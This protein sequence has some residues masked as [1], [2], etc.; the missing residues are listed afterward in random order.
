MDG[1][2]AEKKWGEMK[3]LIAVGILSGSLLGG[4]AMGAHAAATIQVF[5]GSDTI[6]TK[7][8]VYARG[9]AAGV[10]D[11]TSALADVLSDP[12]TAPADPTTYIVRIDRC[13][14][15]HATADVVLEQWAMGKWQ[16]TA[17]TGDGH[18]SAASVMLGE[19][20]K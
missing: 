13:L 16:I 10:S 9:Y 2:W 14:D 4:M 12:E 11:A 3:K 6:R 8:E 5:I 18:W 7:P 19:A 20:C 1:R 17:G 15:R